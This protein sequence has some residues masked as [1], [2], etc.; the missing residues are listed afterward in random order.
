[1]TG[2]YAQQIHRDTMPGLPGGAK[3]SRPKWA[4]L[5][6][7]MLKPLGYRAYHLVRGIST[8]RP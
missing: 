2:Y 1:M 5:L 4:P 6:S 7:T 3:G 8:G